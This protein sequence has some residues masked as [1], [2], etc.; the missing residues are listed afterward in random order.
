MKKRIL[1]A[2]CLFAILCTATGKEPVRVACV[3]NS[4]TYGYGLKNR[5][6]ESYPVVL[7][8]MLGDGYEVRN[9][10]ISARTLL[11]KGD[12]PYMQEALFAEAREF[13]P[14]IVIIK[15]GTNDTKPHNWVH[16]AEFAHDLAAMV[17]SFRTGGNPQIFL[18]YPAKV[19]N[20]QWSIN[21]STLVHC[22]I[23]LIKKVA[24]QKRTRL[25]DLHTPTDG[26]PENFPDRVHPN[27]DGARI[28]ATE[29]YKAITTTRKR[30]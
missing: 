18:C 25:I 5:S 26:M 1:L 10:G 27:A 12:H 9:F 21:D 16:G 30:R 7:G 24:H 15:L 3:G 22:I 6:Q 28:L 17:D 14:D 4:I 8:E 2:I 19:Y 11:N 23:P 20:E 13:R 29:V